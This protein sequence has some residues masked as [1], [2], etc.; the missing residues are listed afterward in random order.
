MQNEVND[1]RKDR[2]RQIGF[3]AQSLAICNPPPDAPAAAEEFVASALSAASTAA[4]TYRQGV[5]GVWTGQGVEMST[6]RARK[7]EV[8]GD[9][10]C[11]RTCVTV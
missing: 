4:C 9:C 3:L 8:R 1:Q 11:V 6:A 5:W 2:N 7:A 10:E